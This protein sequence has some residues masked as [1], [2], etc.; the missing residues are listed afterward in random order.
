MRN[1]SQSELRRLIGFINPS[2]TSYILGLLGC[3]LIDSI[4]TLVLPLMLKFI[5]DSIVSKNMIAI[6]TVCIVFAVSI[7]V[8][9]GLAGLAPIVQYWFG[10]AVKNIMAEFRLHIVS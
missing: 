6:W 8:L 10:K 5:L 7:T 1:K 4:L 2:K 3:C 9:T